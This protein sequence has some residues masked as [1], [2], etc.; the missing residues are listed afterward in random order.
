MTDIDLVTHERVERRMVA[1]YVREGDVIIEGGAGIGAVTRVLL[2][3]GATV[4]AYEPNPKPR[5]E[6]DTLAEA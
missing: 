4:Y 2:D 1:R 5:A 3:V 6:L